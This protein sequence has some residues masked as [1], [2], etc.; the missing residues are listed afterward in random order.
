MKEKDPHDN[1][2][3]TFNFDVTW[4]EKPIKFHLPTITIKDKHMSL[5]IPTV[6]MVD[7]DIIFHIPECRMENQVVGRYPEIRG[8]TVIW[9]DI[10]TKVP[11][12][13]SKEQRIVIGL[14]QISMQRQDFIMSVPNIEMREIEINIKYPEFK[15]V[16]VAIEMKE[17]SEKLEADTKEKLRTGF[18]D[19]KSN[20]LE[21]FKSKHTSLFEC[22]RS[23]L[24]TKKNEA[25]VSIDGI[26]TG[27]NTAI[28]QMK[29]KNVPSDNE[30]LKQAKSILQDIV[31][32]RS[33]IDSQFEQNLNERNAQQQTSLES[34]IQKFDLNIK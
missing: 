30:S 11:V 27:L 33:S 15:L 6:T 9:K 3:L 25:L 20:I 18:N 19:I 21:E 13:E 2:G 26:I 34:F 10:I 29:E 12:C 8:T 5:D 22:L 1:T 23:D 7:K 32:K 24:L 4:T 14:P 28:T 31:S 17:K 16:N